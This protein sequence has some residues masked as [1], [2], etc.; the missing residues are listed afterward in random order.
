MALS[1]KHLFEQCWFLQGNNSQLTKAASI[2]TKY[3]SQRTLNPATKA[4]AFS[5]KLAGNTDEQPSNW[6]KTLRV[7]QLKGTVPCRFISPERKGSFP[8]LTVVK[9]RSENA[10][11]SSTP[12][13]EM[14]LMEA[15]LCSSRYPLH[16]FHQIFWAALAHL[17]TVCSEEHR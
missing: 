1:Q 9:K 17:H 13:K 15:T 16:F 10:K 14:P 3:N 5:I 2:S 8:I 11:A 12:C 7:Q 6:N 4:G